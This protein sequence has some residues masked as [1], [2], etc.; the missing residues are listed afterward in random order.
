MTTTNNIDEVQF[1]PNL[2]SA[3]AV[4]TVVVAA[5]IM[6]MVLTLSEER[7]SSF[8]LSQLAVNSLFVQWVALSSAALLCALRQHLNRLSPLSICLLVIAL[9]P[10]VAL[11][12]SALAQMIH[13]WLQGFSLFAQLL[14]LEL[15]KNSLIAVM[16]TAVLMH[17]FYLQDVLRRKR[18]SEISAR[19]QALQSRIRP[20]FLFNS[21]N[22]IASLIATNPQQAEKAVEDLSEL[23]RA[24]LSDISRQ[25]TLADELALCQSYA[26]IERLRLG[27]R[28]QV[29]INCDPELLDQRM[30]ILLLQPLLENAVYHGVQPLKQGGVV[31][32]RVV[33]DASNVRI[34]LTNPYVAE[35]R[36][37]KGN[38][39]ALDNIK[40]R[41]A[42]LY[43][44]QGAL[45]ISY[46]TGRF[47]VD[48]CLPRYSANKTK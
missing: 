21:M 34:T 30:P 23:F 28:L 31:S 43:G 46:P 17:Y 1:L 36:K 25:V 8:S 12:F 42:T 47:Q 7:L 9:V 6:A 27:D 39:M 13:N 32:I 38:R 14:Q 15:L 5:E 4:L 19:L 44:S 2:C 16:L 45:K 48:I 3:N 26:D 41:V 29:N 18:E 37:H 33:A 20:H 24:S 22:S 11:L 40:R 35:Q 10:C